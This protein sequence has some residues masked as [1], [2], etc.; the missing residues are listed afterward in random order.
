MLSLIHVLIQG[1]ARWQFCKPFCSRQ[2]CA[3]LCHP[4]LEHTQAFFNFAGEKK[5]FLYTHTLLYLKQ[6]F[7][8]FVFQ[9]SFKS[10]I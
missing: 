4:V 5:S 8:L 2:G 10:L 7:F 9:R 3:K 6:R 1:L